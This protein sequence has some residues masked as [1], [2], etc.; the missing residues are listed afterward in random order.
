MG[1][2]MGYLVCDS[3]GGYYELQQGESEDDF[4]KCQC[5]GQ[6]SLKDRISNDSEIKEE[7]SLICP[8]CFEKYA[9]GIFCAKC[10]SDLISIKNVSVANSME[11]KYKKEHKPQVKTKNPRLNNT[12]YQRIPYEERM[13]RKKETEVEGD[14][15]K[16]EK[17]PF[18]ER[19]RWPGVIAGGLASLLSTS[20]LYGINEILTK[21][22]ISQNYGSSYAYTDSISAIVSAA[23]IILILGAIFLAGSGAIASYIARSTDYS[24]GILNAFLSS[25]LYV[26][27]FGI[28]LSILSGSLFGLGLVIFISYI[29]ITLF[30]I[31]GVIGTYIRKKEV[32]G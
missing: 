12:S 24:D 22:L 29:P 11:E 4:D 9:S 20:L 18:L 2:F 14:D 30:V 13:T 26:L 25:L 10:G 3:C 27:I 5:G 31:G 6:L 16:I 28:I 15:E 23:V 1:G 17:P 19:I 7:P 32:V 8:H 21:S